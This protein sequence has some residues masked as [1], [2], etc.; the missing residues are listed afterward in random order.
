MRES[1]L[2]HQHDNYYKYTSLR[3]T[4]SKYELILHNIG[5]F[6][7]MGG[8]KMGWC[9]WKIV[10]LPEIDIKGDNHRELEFAME[11]FNLQHNI[12]SN[13]LIPQPLIGP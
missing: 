7:S 8:I 3:E 13:R 1:L 12:I 5:S 4:S 6:H 2:K 10:Q 9:T 11:D